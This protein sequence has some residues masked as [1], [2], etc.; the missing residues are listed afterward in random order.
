MWT[1]GILVL[2]QIHIHPK[3][4]VQ[5]V[6]ILPAHHP[7]I[8]PFLLAPVLPEFLRETQLSL[9][10]DL[11]ILYLSQGVQDTNP[12]VPTLPRT[13]QLLLACAP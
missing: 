10:V 8:L 7:K 3:L 2:G 13:R 6:P 5:E 9:P 1:C 12:Q 4:C 11:L